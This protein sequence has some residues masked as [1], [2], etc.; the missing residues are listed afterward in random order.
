ML[1]LVSLTLLVQLSDIWQLVVTSVKPMNT[2]KTK[3]LHTA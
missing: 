3:Q 1:V 2:L